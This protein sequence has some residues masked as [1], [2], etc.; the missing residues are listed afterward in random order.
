MS[1]IREEW[2]TTEYVRDIR[3]VYRLAPIYAVKTVLGERKDALL[4]VSARHALRMTAANVC[5]VV[6]AV[7]FF[8]NGGMKFDTMWQHVI[9]FAV[10]MV[11][12]TFRPSGILGEHTQEKV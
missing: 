6:L 3:R 11:I 4:A 10:L 8:L 2:R 7:V 12:L 5:L 9:A 1:H